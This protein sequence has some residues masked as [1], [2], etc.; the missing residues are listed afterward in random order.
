[1]YK[2]F[3]SVCRQ[4]CLIVAFSPLFFH[5]PSARGNDVE[6]DADNSAA[7]LARLKSDGAADAFCTTTATGKTFAPTKPQQAQISKCLPLARH[8][9]ANAENSYYHQYF[10]TYIDFATHA[11]KGKQSLLTCEQTLEAQFEASEK[12]IKEMAKLDK[13]PDRASPNPDDSKGV[14][15]YLKEIGTVNRLY[16]ATAVEPVFLRLSN[17]DK[18]RLKKCRDLALAACESTQST[19]YKSFFLAYS[20]YADDVLTGRD[21]HLSSVTINAKKMREAETSIALASQ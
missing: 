3:V 7:V 12:K 15:A 4:V 16:L 18:T 5:L 21:P 19:G 11:L 1:M 20:D 6:T 8:A 2:L 14:L 9:S 17:D 13:V 10:E